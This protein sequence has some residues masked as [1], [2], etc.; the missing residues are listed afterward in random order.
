MILV[1]F[2]FEIVYNVGKKPQ[3]HTYSL[4]TQPTME[5]FKK[6]VSICIYTIIPKDAWKPKIVTYLT[7]N[8]IFNDIQENHKTHFIRIKFTFHYYSRNTS[9]KGIDNVSCTCIN[10]VQSK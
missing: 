4:L 3:Y 10:V 2:D 6:T 7:T 1:E 8:K 5:P 9:Q